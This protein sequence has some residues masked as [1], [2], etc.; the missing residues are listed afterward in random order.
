MVSLVSKTIMDL[1][2]PDSLVKL[3]PSFLNSTVFFGMQ[4]VTIIFMAI[5]SVIMAIGI[6]QVP[7]HS[8]DL[9]LSENESWVVVRK[10]VPVEGMEA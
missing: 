2:N 4:V 5:H 7:K 6:L 1:G 8:N 10:I 3:V 9:T